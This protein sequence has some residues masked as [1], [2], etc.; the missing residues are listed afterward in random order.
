[1]PPEPP[2]RMPPRPQRAAPIAY[3]SAPTPEP[4]DPRLKFPDR[5]ID[6]YMPLALLGALFGLDQSD[7]WYCVCVI[8]LVNVATYFSL[9]GLRHLL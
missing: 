7:T 6:L 1:M 2:S 5:V 8:F 3:Q 4:I 9:L